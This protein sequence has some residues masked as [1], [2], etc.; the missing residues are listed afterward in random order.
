MQNSKYYTFLFSACTVSAIFGV[1][2]GYFIFG[3]IGVS[4]GVANSNGANYI[5]PYSENYTIYD[6]DDAQESETESTEPAHN[7]ILTVND[8]YIV[9]LHAGD[10][11]IKEV[12]FTPANTL[13]IE[14]QERLAQGIRVYTEEALIRILEDFGS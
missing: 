11:D 14:D 1:A 2:L 13:P 3:P 12:T 4:A 6:Y 9:V 10:E 8:G 5:E 7:Y